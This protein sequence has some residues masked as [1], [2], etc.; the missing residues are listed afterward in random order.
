MGIRA[1]GEHGRGTWELGL[2]IL[3]AVLRTRQSKGKEQ[4]TGHSVGDNPANSVPEEESGE[5]CGA[6]TVRP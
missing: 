2:K 1:L 3:Q 6:H 5:V 4:G